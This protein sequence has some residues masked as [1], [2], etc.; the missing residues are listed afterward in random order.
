[1]NTGLKGK[2]VN[3]IIEYFFG[4]LNRWP[5]VQEHPGQYTQKQ[6][7]VICQRIHDTG[8]CLWH[9]TCEMMVWTNCHCAKCDK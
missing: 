9:A 7:T 8:N 6:I 3:E 2:P 1:M 5:I 4:D